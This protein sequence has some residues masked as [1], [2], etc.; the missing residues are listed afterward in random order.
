MPRRPFLV[1]ALS[2]IVAFQHSTTLWAWGRLAPELVARSP[3]N[4]FGLLS[5]DHKAARTV[6]TT[7]GVMAS[8]ENSDRWARS[9]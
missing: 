5:T 2:V 3:A 7:N 1:I 6:G 9:Q 8:R 4:E